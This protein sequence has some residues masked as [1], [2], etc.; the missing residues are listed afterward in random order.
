M[1]RQIL[2]DGSGGWFDIDECKS[3]EGDDSTVL[4]KTKGGSFILHTDFDSDVVDG[5]PEWMKILDGEA[6]DWL[7]SNGYFDD[8]PPGEQK[9][10]KL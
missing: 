6:Y 1:R 5:P 3:W 7:V 4:Y 2:S 8:V 9:K 10:R